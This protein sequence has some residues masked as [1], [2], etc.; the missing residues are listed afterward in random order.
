MVPIHSFS[1]ALVP[2]SVVD[3]GHEILCLAFCVSVGFIC[4]V[5]NQAVF[6]GSRIA[7]RALY[8]IGAVD[9]S[10]FSLFPCFVGLSLS[11]AGNVSDRFLVRNSECLRVLWTSR[12]TPRG[13]TAY[14]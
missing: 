8:V 13:P 14:D 3:Q 9:S 4:A 5:F 11:A 7:V 12:S 1:F 6:Y 2:T 10:V